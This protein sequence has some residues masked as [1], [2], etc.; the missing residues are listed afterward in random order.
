MRIVLVGFG[1]VGQGFVEL[2]LEKDDYLKSEIDLKWRVVSIIDPKY[3]NIMNE[4]GIDVKIALDVARRGEKFSKYNLPMANKSVEEILRG[5]NYDVMVE[6]TPTNLQTGEPAISFIKFALTSGHH[7]ITTNKG[8]C[9]LFLTELKHLAKANGVLFKYEGTVMSGTPV[10]NLIEN[11][12]RGVE[13]KKVKGIVNGTCNFILTCMEEG[14][15]YDEALEKAQ[16]LGY[17][18][19]DPTADVEGWDSVAKLLI[20][21][22]V[23]YGVKIPI[24]EVKR[25]G[26]THLTLED[27]NLAKNESKT[28]KLI[29]SLEKTDDGIIATVEPRKIP[30]GHPLSIVRGVLNAITFT[31]D[32]L[33]ELTVI[34]PGAGARE[35]GFALLSD[36]ISIYKSK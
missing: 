11:N 34:G 2:L 32:C 7:V 3:G 27:V 25:Q 8:P 16:R 36:L 14:I 12:L 21:A 18:E 26:I 29:A 28:W 10:I 31:T 17:A 13:I 20:L 15:S 23:I 24:N 19:T 33:T 9:A 4:D 35:T 5:Q 22:Q 30:F 6:V 1:T